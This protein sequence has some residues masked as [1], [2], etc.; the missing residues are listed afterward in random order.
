MMAGVDTTGGAATFLLYHLAANPGQQE[1]VYQEIVSAVGRAGRPTEQQLGRLRLLR[2]AAQ[3]SHRLR[4]V[5]AGVSRRTQK[6]VPN[7]INS[8]FNTGHDI[9]MYFLKAV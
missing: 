8:L 4:P 2:A 9:C 6:Q 7:V 5:A 1:A 3:E